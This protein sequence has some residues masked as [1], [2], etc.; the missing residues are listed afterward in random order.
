MVRPVGRGPN[1]AD[2]AASADRVRLQAN[3]DE[4]LALLG[5]LQRFTVLDLFDAEGRQIPIWK[6]PRNVAAAI[7][8][9][10]PTKHGTVLEFRDT[11]HPAE[12]RLKVFGRLKESVKVES[13]T[14]EEILAR[15]WETQDEQKPAP[16]NGD[17]G[18]AP[19]R[20]VQPQRSTAE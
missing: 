6:L 19:G 8:G 7:K 1:H 9:I 13:V 2:P 12:V 14:L 3:G 11:V 16:A 18:P 10:R 15:S 20:A 5:D 4:E 17:A